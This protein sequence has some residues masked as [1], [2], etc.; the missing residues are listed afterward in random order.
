MLYLSP[1][2]PCTITVSTKN[3]SIWEDFISYSCMFLEMLI[4]LI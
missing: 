2:P 4:T 1:L 3:L